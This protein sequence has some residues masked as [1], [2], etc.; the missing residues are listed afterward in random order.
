M[1]RI[2]VAA[3]LTV[4]TVAA[5]LPAIDDARATR[6]DAA[7]EAT[8]DRLER[9]GRSLATT[10]DAAAS[11]AL[12]ATRTVAFE[13]PSRSLTAARPSFVA[14]GGPPDG[15][16]NRSTVTYAT[17]PS[18]RRHHLP[19]PVPVRTPNGPVVF[20][21]PG[22]HAVSIALVRGSDGPV[23]SVTRGPGS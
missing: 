5:A 7:I 14:V 21:D 18:P 19:L 12:A 11:R 23:L 20:E 9:V 17:S 16:G 15:P 2:V 8:A 4:A 10:E 6:T 1:I 13:L 22:R 3:V